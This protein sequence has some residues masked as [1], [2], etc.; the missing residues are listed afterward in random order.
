MHGVLISYLASYLVVSAGLA[1]TSCLFLLHYFITGPR[2]EP[3]VLQCLQFMGLTS[4][5][6]H[7][8]LFGPEF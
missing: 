8:Y 2:C 7:I 4:G 6:L 5:L 3:P 1:I